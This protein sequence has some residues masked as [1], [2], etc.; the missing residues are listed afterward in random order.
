MDILFHETYPVGK[1]NINNINCKCSKC[2]IVKKNIQLGKYI[3]Y[4]KDLNLD[5][6][7]FIEL[8]PNITSTGG[9]CKPNNVLWCSGGTWLFD[10]YCE[11]NHL[12]ENDIIQEKV[13]VID[14][15]KHPLKNIIIVDDIHKFQQFNKLFLKGQKINWDLVKEKCDAVAFI[16]RKTRELIDETNLLK[17][18]KHGWYSGFD[19]ETL[20]IFDTKCI[21]GI[22]N[23]ENVSF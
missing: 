16:F 22:M 10:Q 17:K 12:D 2:E 6:N 20:I 19:V 23:I 9:F 18:I 5:N 15:E 14:T 13:L 21:D 11:Q 3:H 1:I 8:K 7:S 4:T